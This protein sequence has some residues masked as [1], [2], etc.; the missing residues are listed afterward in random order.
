MLFQ[1]VH[2]GKVKHMVYK[3]EFLTNKTNISSFPLPYQEVNVHCLDL[4][5]LPLS[6]HNLLDIGQTMLLSLTNALS[7]QI[8]TSPLS[9]MTQ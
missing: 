8:F 3:P 2:Y 6:H 1:R 7:L 4:N 9:Q 5:I